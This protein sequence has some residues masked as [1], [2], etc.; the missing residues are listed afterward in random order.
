MIVTPTT[1]PDLEARTVVGE[2]TGRE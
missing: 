1:G 2:I